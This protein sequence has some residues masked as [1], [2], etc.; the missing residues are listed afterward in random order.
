ME[1]AL[2]KTQLC[3]YD[4]AAEEEILTHTI[5]Y[6]GR[7]L[8]RLAPKAPYKYLGV[9]LTVTHYWWY[10]N[11]SVIEKV[12]A[13][14]AYLKDTVYTYTQLDQVVHMC[15]IPLFQCSAAIVQWT[16]PELSTI[17]KLFNKSTRLAWKLPQSFSG[18][19]LQSPG[20]Q[21]GHSS[22]CAQVL[23]FQEMWGLY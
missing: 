2:E 21:G 15:I 7:E 4:F 17:T 12:A 20:V 3:A 10:E 5:R 16:V 13:A 19:V 14:T 8:L 11:A 6:E 18:N 9:R 23:Q 22:P 1:V